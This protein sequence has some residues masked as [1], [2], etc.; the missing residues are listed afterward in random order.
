MP[1]SAIGLQG[2]IGVQDNRNHI[3]NG[4]FNIWQR[5]VTAHYGMTG[6]TGQTRVHNMFNAD[7]WRLYISAVNGVTC[8]GII[9][10]REPFDL[11]DPSGAENASNWYMNLFIGGTGASAAYSGADA[12]QNYGGFSGAGATTNGSFAALIQ[13]IE[14]VK[15][16]ENKSATVS[17]WAKSDIAGQ[18]IAPVLIQVT[19]G[20]GGGLISGSTGGLGHT[21]DNTWRK[22]ETSFTVPGLESDSLGTSGDNAL[23]LQLLFQAHAGRAGIGVT[24]ELG[25]V[26]GAGKTGNIKIA[27]VQLE[28]GTK[29]TEFD[30]KD[31]TV[32]IMQCRRYFEKSY[33]LDV[34]PGSYI[35]GGLPSS[36]TT[37]EDAKG[38]RTIPY[39]D[40][41]TILPNMSFTVPKVKVP[42]CT[43]YH[44]FQ[45]N[46]ENKFNYGSSSVGTAS[47]IEA[48]ENTITKWTGPDINAQQV[49]Y[50][51]IANAEL[52]VTTI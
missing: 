29:V 1:Y 2:P 21:L 43:I 25:G 15:T 48:S 17:F 50:H 26:P 31:R 37:N 16:L 4:D 42:T 41:T 49:H 22:Y 39:M 8:N 38:Y 6:H 19:G 9:A 5:G 28:Q 34:K 51:Y 14:D 35:S 46:N 24:F 44:P 32:E 3:I 18:R 27:Q 30:Q 40:N 13:D 52:N 47:N 11:G 45:E 12:T 36:A 23:Q 20:A 33:D 7:R 10:S